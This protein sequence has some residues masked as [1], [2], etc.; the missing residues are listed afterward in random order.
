MKL[1]AFGEILWDIVGEEKYL[2]GAPFNL[3]VHAGRCGLQAGIVSSLGSDPLGTEA[4]AAANSLGVD[5]R[6]VRVV[7]DTP[8][9]RV[10]VTVSSEGQPHYVIHEHVA[11]DVIGL[12]AST[13]TAILAEAYDVFCF[14]TLVQR[15]ETSRASLRRLLE[16]FGGT[17]TRIFC[18]VNL[19][20]HYYDRDILEKSLQAT[21]I[22]KLNDE[23]AVTVSQMFLAEATGSLGELCS[24]LARQFDLSVVLITLGAAGAG[25]YHEDNYT[26]VPGHSV[27]VADTIGA[28]DAFSAAFL[29][30]YLRNGDPV[31]AVHVANA[32]GAYVA[33]KPG[34]LPPYEDA[35]YEIL[36]RTK[37]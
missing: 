35:Q 34:A 32:I 21:H 26:I 5:C 29:N 37:S 13:Q 6:F 11:F 14:G 22:L 19:R 15:F 9:G 25:V 33:S 10:D 16:A 27:E 18:D 7:P 17:S 4:W 31:T 23:E 24:E 20:Q 28:G 12:E 2:G 8:T 1:L 3:A 36:K 30:D